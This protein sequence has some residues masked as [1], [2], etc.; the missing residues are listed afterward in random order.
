MRTV[1]IR[2]LAESFADKRRNSSGA[3]CDLLSQFRMLTKS[4]S[5][6]DRRNCIGR[7]EG[8]LKNLQI[9]EAFG[10]HGGC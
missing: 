2:P 9:F 5:I 3:V 7:F 6:E 4:R 10:N 1:A 8:L